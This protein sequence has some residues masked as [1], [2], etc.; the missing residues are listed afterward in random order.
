MPQHTVEDLEGYYDLVLVGLVGSKAYGL[1][2]AGSDEDYLG[3]FQLETSTL[4]GLGRP[5]ETVTNTHLDHPGVPDYTYQE[6]GKF[7]KLALAGNP[8]IL[9]LLW[10]DK[11]VTQP[12]S[13]A[14]RSWGCGRPSSLTGYGIL[15]RLRPAAARAHESARR[16]RTT[17]ERSTSGTC[18]GSWPRDSTSSRPAN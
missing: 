16:R 13:P 2:H 1:D 18:S 4:L 3:V 14:P 5:H 6:L 8:T 10:L 12:T 15:R 17:E 7:V 9:E 11:Y